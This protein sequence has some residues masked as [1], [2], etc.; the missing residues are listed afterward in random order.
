MR[1]VVARRVPN[2]RDPV[3][4]CRQRAVPEHESLL[5]AGTRD[6]QLLRRPGIA[7]AGATRRN[8]RDSIPRT[9]CT[10]SERA[11][12]GLAAP[13]SSREAKTARRSGV[14]DNRV[15]KAASE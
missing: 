9:L 11:M 5:Q 7:E 13:G 10:P 14:S 1:M 15:E 6:G 2:G 3:D 12:N 8:A 4:P